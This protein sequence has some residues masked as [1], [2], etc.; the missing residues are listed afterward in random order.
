MFSGSLVYDSILCPREIDAT[1]VRNL[2]FWSASSSLV[3]LGFLPLLRQQSKVRIVLLIG[4]LIQPCLLY[5]VG[6]HF[7]LPRPGN[8]R[9]GL[10]LVVP[11]VFALASALDSILTEWAAK[12]YSVAGPVLITAL[13]VLLWIS[14]ADF[15][16]VYFMLGPSTAAH[17]TYRTATIEPKSRTY[18]VLIEDI[19]QR[20]LSG[21]RPKPE[22]LAEDYWLSYPMAFL[23][24][25]PDE[26]SLPPTQ[27]AEPVRLSV[28]APVQAL[29]GGAYV[30][31]WF[32]S[33]MD[34]DVRR[35]AV[36]IPVQ[37][38]LISDGAS[39]PIVAIY[40]S[41]Q[42]ELRPPK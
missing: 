5:L 2:I 17:R 28:K 14:L 1:R 30:V 37:K 25:P 40:R 19:R 41:S 33:P 24:W 20:V 15:Y 35:S 27:R 16:R 42:T 4:A 38:W 26:V 39:V 9:Y 23:N 34:R 6:G 36:G 12:G 11:L 29:L 22:V 13:S 18:Q 31:T 3:L 32:D 21:E 10:F 7:I 8:E